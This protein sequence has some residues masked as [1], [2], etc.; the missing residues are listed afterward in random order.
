MTNE[1]RAFWA[2]L[3]ISLSAY[4]CSTTPQARLLAS[5][6][7]GSDPAATTAGWFCRNLSD[8]PGIDGSIFTKSYLEKLAAQLAEIHQTSDWAF[9][10]LNQAMIAEYRAHG[11]CEGIEEFKD[12]FAKNNPFRVFLLKHRDGF[13]FVLSLRVAGDGLI[14]DMQGIGDADNPIQGDALLTLRDLRNEVKARDGV[15]LRTLVFT[16]RG[17]ES[18]R[19]PVVLVRT[20]YFQTDGMFTLTKWVNTARFWTDRGYAYVLQAVRGT[21]GSQG[22]YK[23]FSPREV[24]DAR[25]TLD[26]IVSQGFSNGK[27][28]VIG[29]SYEGFTSIAAGITHHPALK[30]VVAGGAPSDNSDG[31]F[32]R[33]GTVWLKE[34]NYLRYNL[35]QDGLVYWPGFESAL[36]GMMKEPDLRKYDRKLFGAEFADWQRIAASFPDPSAPFWKEREIHSRIGEISAPT[37][38]IGGMQNVG[39]AEHGKGDCCGGD[40]LGNYLKGV[41][42]PHPKAHHVILG[43]WAH[44]DSTP[45]GDGTNLDPLVRDRIP[46]IMDHYLQGKALS[47]ADD[48]VFMASNEKGRALRGASYPLPELGK[49]VLY[50]R[51]TGDR[52]L[53]SLEAPSA[54]NS[55]EYS[56]YQDIPDELN[57]LMNL[58]PDSRQTLAFDFVAP[59]DM[60]ILGDMAVDLHV[61]LDVPQADIYALPVVIGKDGK[62]KPIPR[63]VTL[64]KLGGRVFRGSGVTKVKTGSCPVMTDLKAGDTLRVYVTSNLYPLFARNTHREIEHFYDGFLN[65]HIKLHHSQRYPSQIRFT[66]EAR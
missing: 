54:S 24:D 8:R 1:T 19:Q 61:E 63:V 42:G 32:I 43:N 59:K 66:T 52:Q 6:S 50:F 49:R 25:D 2:A 60:P 48:A 5:V 64:C 11:A 28:G 29:V 22:R 33:N 3:A 15:S 46:A 56:T 4:A 62:G 34:L 65:A 9:D 35:A 17:T 36:I 57:D 18:S 13:E 44:G 38:H 55:G 31:S 27:I 41:S 10:Q 40:S 30:V 26:W 45:Y 16:K 58:N 14:E 23:I 47:F 7:P 51:G 20:P 39:G 37:Y 21:G 53:L 12:S